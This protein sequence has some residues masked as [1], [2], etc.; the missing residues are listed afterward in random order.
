MIQS[1]AIFRC[2]KHEL[3]LIVNTLVSSIKS[4]NFDTSSLRGKTVLLKPNMLGAYPPK[5]GITTHPLFVEAVII[6]FKEYGCK[7]WLGDSPNGIF[8]IDLVWERTGIREI[9]KRHNVTE[10]VFERE[11]SVVKNGLHIAKPLVEVDLVVNL[12]KFKTH[13][14]TILTLATKNLY[15][16]IPGLVKT[17]YH[18]KYRG[19]ERFAEMLVRIAGTVSPKLTLIDG[20]VGMDGNGPSAGRLI[21]L[22]LIIAGTDVFHT[23]AVCSSLVGLNPL[24]LDTLVAAKKLNLWNEND[25]T[26]VTGIN[27][28]ENII[29]DFNLPSTYTK[30]MRDWW[31]SKFVIKR[32]WG[33]ISI[34]PKVN[35]KKCK[36]CGLCIK[37]CPVKAIEGKQSGSDEKLKEPPKIITKKC[38]ECYCCHEICPYKAIDLNQSLFIKIGRM[39]GERRIKKINNI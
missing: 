21:K 35:Q 37:S 4:I 1:V 32:I 28:H 15:G 9:C 5:M 2:N 6:L 29:K 3:K 8:P 26:I 17:S 22:G 30:G 16:C 13:G 33:G 19:N 36:R 31:I 27:P 38:I 14:L 11:G 25:E 7:V 12:P 24:N 39:L 34:K 20:I 23:D 18:R 10:K